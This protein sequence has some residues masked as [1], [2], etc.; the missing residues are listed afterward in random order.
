MQLETDALIDL[1]RDL[2]QHPEPSWCE[3]YTTAR[4][5]DVLEERD[6]DE[7]HVGPDAYGDDD[8]MAVPDETTR[9]E[10]RERAVEAGADPD[11]VSRLDDG[12]TGAVA[13]VRKGDGPVVGL[14]VDI[15]GLPIEE[16]TADDHE[17]AV[18]G[19]RSETGYMHACG[20][21]AHTTVGIGVID[22]VLE[23]DFDGKLKVFFQ[24]AEEKG[25][26]GGPMSRSP[27][28]ADVAYLYAVHIG[29]DHPTGEIVAAVDGF[30]AVSG[31]DV[32]FE[33]SPAHAGAHPEEGDN[34][35]QAMAEAISSI[36]A[37]PRHG[38]GA[39]RVNAGV[40][41]GGT[42][43]NIIAE[44][45]RLQAEVR[46]ATTELMEYMWAETGSVIDAAADMHGVEAT[47]SRLSRAPSATSDKDLAQF[48]ADAA[49]EVE[50]V[51][52]IMDED[53]LGGSEDA[54]YL[55]KEVQENGGKA[56]YIGLGTDHP[57][58]HHT[59]KFDVDE[60]SLRIGVETLA[61]AIL[62]LGE[63]P[64]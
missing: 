56:C 60:E 42:A 29:L 26:G 41:E 31:F 34:A 63:N 33:G 58:G 9:R 28:L 54:T 32:E 4:I 10:W 62:A 5:V 46:G 64:A 20:H 8:R 39:T 55:M 22:A 53:D 49:R 48:V 27:L 25:S 1:R 11:L 36:Y 52:S 37:I 12:N 7:L 61:G 59:S 24:P 51:D 43:S 3:F 2:H 45:A 17:P 35:I 19:F 15:D 21:D 57:D 6:L 47:R 16:S 30:L 40:V 50:G 18:E 23:S 44:E 13:V 38:D 14:R